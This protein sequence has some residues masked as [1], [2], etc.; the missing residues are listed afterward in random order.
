MAFIGWT[1]VGIFSFYW[2]EWLMLHDDRLLGTGIKR[3]YLKLHNWASKRTGF[4]S[5]TA[6]HGMPL[7]GICDMFLMN[8]QSGRWYDT[9]KGPTPVQLLLPALMHIELMHL[10]TNLKSVWGLSIFRAD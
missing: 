6:S 10:Y 5:P 9:S 8:M 3:H 2:A 4:D 1:Y 7:Y